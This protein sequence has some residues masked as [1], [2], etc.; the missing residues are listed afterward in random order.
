[1]APSGTWRAGAGACP[2]ETPD[3]SQKNIQGPC[4]MTPPPAPGVTPEQNAGRG[5]GG[6]SRATEGAKFLG[7][8][9]WLRQGAWSL[10]LPHLHGDGWELCARPSLLHRSRP[11]PEVMSS[12][13]LE[14][15]KQG[16]TLQGGG[17]GDCSTW[18]EVG[19]FILGRSG[20]TWVSALP[21][22]TSGGRP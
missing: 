22:P 17:G 16:L 21:T 20:V 19:L 4:G 6:R 13:V 9:L 7:A 12:P 1:M 2:P 5:L 10:L 18:L 15:F 3:S 14:V 11:L 8:G